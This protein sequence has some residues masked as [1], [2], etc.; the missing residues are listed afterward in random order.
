[1]DKSR[2]I[3]YLGSTDMFTEKEIDLIML[4]VINSCVE[5]PRG[6]QDRLLELLEQNKVQ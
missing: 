1:M 5:I 6:L 2:Y 4:S 3:E